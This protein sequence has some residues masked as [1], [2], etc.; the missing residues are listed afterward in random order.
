[1]ETEFCIASDTNYSL[2]GSVQAS[3]NE[4][5]GNITATGVVSIETVGPSPMFIVN[6]QATNGQDVPI[7][8][9]LPLTAGCYDMIVEVFADALPSGTGAGSASSSCNVLLSPQ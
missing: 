9:S 4:D 1:M 6:E 8:M 7:S 2:T 5:I 3:A